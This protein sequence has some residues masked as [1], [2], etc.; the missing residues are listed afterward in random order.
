[1]RFSGW[2]AACAL[3]LA[4]AVGAHAAEVRVLS[5]GVVSNS[6]LREVGAA[7]TAKT[8]V[9]VTV[10]SAGM[11]EII[12]QLKTAPAPSDIVMLPMDLMGTVALE[13]AILPG[14]FTPLARAKIALFKK[15]GAPRP[16]ISTVDKLA[17]VMKAASVVMYTDPVSGSRQASIS[18]ELLM[19]PKFAGV[20]GLG[21][22]GDAE[23]ALK[24][25]D[26][27]AAALGLGL[28]HDSL[29][30]GQADN[31]FLV[32]TLPSELGAHMDMATAIS[33]RAPSPK[34]AEAF[35][36]F[37]K[38]PQARVLWRQKGLDPY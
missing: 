11:A 5:P 10:V 9:K 27:D 24:R 12:G 29:Q 15:A 8:G 37:M 3:V 34:E 14:T 19:Q 4:S 21:I 7:Y 25:G 1:M 33:A 2:I 38:T 32:D 30:S 28:I 18:A 22:K 6:G 36:A 20:K 17:G 35:I 31:P 26:G 13:K 16:D 23:P